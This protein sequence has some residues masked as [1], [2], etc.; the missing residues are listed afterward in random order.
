MNPLFLTDGYKISHHRQ[1]PKGT[2]LVYSNFTPR[3]N[4][5]APEINEVINVGVQYAIQK[6][7]DVF[8]AEF[9]SKQKG[10]VMG[11][12]ESELFMYVG[13][14]YDSSHMAALHDLGYLPIVVKSLPEGISVPMRTPLLTIYNTLPD[15]FWVTNYLET[16]LSNMLWLPMTSAS[17]AMRYRK[18]LEKFCL[19]TDKDNISVVDF[20]AHDFS[21]RGMG[22]TE[23]TI[24]SGIGH[25]AVF[26]GSDNLPIIPEIRKVY[27]DDG[28]L[29]GGVPATEHSVM[30]SGSKDSEIETF[31]TLL[32]E[33]PTGILSIVSDTWDLWKVCTEY[34]PALKEQIMARNG[35]LVIR[36]DS[37]DPVDIICGKTY[38]S[39]DFRDIVENADMDMSAPEN[40]GVIELLWETF[41]GTINEQGYKVL[42]A[43]IGCIYGDS[44]TPERAE[45]ICERLKSK[46]FASTNIVLGIGSYTYQ[47]KTRDTFGFAMKATYV[48]I[49][50]EGREIFKNPITDSGIKKSAKGL[51]RVNK[52]LSL[53]DQCSWEE[54]R[55]GELK[56]IYRDGVF[57]SKTPFADVRNRVINK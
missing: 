39:R 28:F 41:G 51:L 10:D 1:Y 3:S 32:K 6:I 17:T 23:A 36:P 56:E 24:L 45:Q 9:F 5:F 8:D 27:G 7:H 29:V 16:I 34:L 26:S 55:A 43:H 14:H 40:K 25:A 48:E 35:K 22:G 31:S 4:K 13:E 12:I 18:I 52:D 46:G 37:G 20:Q 50:G 49:N 33:F 11:E 57:V 54:E 21:M 30:C 53:T 47:Y 15:F 38:P 19:E 42:D 44:I 2:T